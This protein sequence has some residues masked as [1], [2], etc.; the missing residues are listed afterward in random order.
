MGEPLFSDRSDVSTIA[1]S[2]DASPYLPL[3]AMWNTVPNDEDGESL[4][5]HARKRSFVRQATID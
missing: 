3:N 4:F 1:S 2:A 5:T